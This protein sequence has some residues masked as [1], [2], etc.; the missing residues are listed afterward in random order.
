ML[1]SRLREQCRLIKEILLTSH[2]ADE[3]RIYE[4]LA[5]LKS[6]LQAG[7]SASGH[8]VAYTRAL[9]YFSTAAY[10]QD[11]TAGIA[12]YRVIA[13]YEEHF[14]EKK[15]AADGEAV[16]PCENHFYSG[17]YAGECNL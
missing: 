8:S 15:A 13:D 7:L 11:A 1:A 14:E 2:L 6:R 3:K 10:C 16:L 17:A 12:C 9:S 5:Q 4:I